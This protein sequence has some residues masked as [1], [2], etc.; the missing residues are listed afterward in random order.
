MFLFYSYLKSALSTVGESIFTKTIS[1][2]EILILF[3]TFARKYIARIKFSELRNKDI[4][5]VAVAFC[6][7]LK[8]GVY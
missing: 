8:K 2:E 4:L 1:R 7:R 5:P 6:M 3:F